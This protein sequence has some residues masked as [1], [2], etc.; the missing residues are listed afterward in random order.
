ML[1]RFPSQ[2]TNQISNRLPLFMIRRKVYRDQVS[3][4]T[5]T[6]EHSQGGRVMRKHRLILTAMVLIIARLVFSSGL[7][8]QERATIVG[9]V[10]D[11]TG[12]IMPDVKVTVTHTG[13]MISRSLV[14]NSAGNYIAPELPIG[15]YSVKAERQ[16]FKTYER[17]GIVLNVNDTLR[18]DISMQVGEITENVNVSEEVVKVQ[19]ESGE[20]SDVISG[21]QVTQ[22]AINGR[23]FFQLAVLTTGA[24]SKMPDFNKPIPV[25][26]DGSI[27]FNGMRP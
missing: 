6:L 8:A 9:T 18:I 21:Q 10:T 13:T 17:T 23:N 15:P 27:S 26:S 12:A 14:T 22:L 25:G 20:V 7:Y 5:L 1:V 24:S 4:K 16:G 19:S 2:P 11:S 3:P